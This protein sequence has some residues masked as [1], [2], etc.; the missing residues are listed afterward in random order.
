MGFVRARELANNGRGAY[1]EHKMDTGT[2]THK[3]KQYSNKK[4]HHGKPDAKFQEPSAPEH[5][6]MDG[7]H[8]SGVKRN[9]L[10]GGKK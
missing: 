7:S 2:K 1:E 6:A 8:T 10:T 5:R 3:M 4:G 9:E